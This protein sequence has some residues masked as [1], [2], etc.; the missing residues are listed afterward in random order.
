MLNFLIINFRHKQSNSFFS[1]KIRVWDKTILAN[2]NPHL[3]K[4]VHKTC[5][6]N[7]NILRFPQEADESARVRTPW[8]I[9]AFSPAKPFVGRTFHLFDAT[10]EYL[11]QSQDVSMG[12]AFCTDPR[13]FDGT[14]FCVNSNL[15]SGRI[16]CTD[17]NPYEEMNF[18][19]RPNPYEETSFLHRSKSLRWDQLFTQA[20][21]AIYVSEAKIHFSLFPKCLSQSPLL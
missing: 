8:I 15:Y 12:S 21:E 19:H 5:S 14:S 16:F 18:L 4:H 17:P 1:I 11:V 7:T 6:G 3:L 2:K 20:Q 13:L 10:K 9:K